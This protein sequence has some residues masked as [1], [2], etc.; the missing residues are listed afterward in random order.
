MIGP[1]RRAA[2]RAERAD[3]LAFCAALAP[4]DWRMNSRAAGW[5][6]QDV[7]AH[8]GAGCHALFTPAAVALMR[9]DDIERANDELV[10]RRRDRLPAEVLGEYRRWSQVFAGSTPVLTAAA[11]N[12]VRVPLA[13]LGRFPVRLVPSAMVFDHHTHLRHDMA[14]VLGRAVPAGDAN[15]MAVVLEWMTAVL[16]NQLRALR[17]AWLDRPVGLTLSGPG[18]GVWRVEPGGAVSPGRAEPAAARITAAA[19]EFPEW[20]TGRASWRDRDVTVDGDEDYATRFLDL[21]KVV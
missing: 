16:S 18:G 14:P 8:L 6:I 10:A 9:G 5:S 1:D 12:R 11:L 17:P 7:V 21:V 15:R 2:F 3:L 20:G 4:A 19:A 13:E